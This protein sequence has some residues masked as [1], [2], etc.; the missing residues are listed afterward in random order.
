MNRIALSTGDIEY[1]DT[2]G[3]GPTVVFLHGWLMDSS[4]WDETIADLSA[5]HRCVAPTLPLGAHRLAMHA[6][7]DLSLPGIA[8]LVT[9]FL[10][11]LELRD[12]T[13]VGNDTGGAFV[14]ILMRD[15]SPRV[16]RVV[17]AS[18]DAFDN[19]PPGLTGKTLA[20]TGKLSPRLFGLF[21]QQM[22]LKFVRR[23]PIAFGWL[24]KRGD[25][26][27]ARWM[28]PVLTRPA[29]RR[30][31]VRMLRAASA[32]KGLLLDAA[33]D[34]PRF[35]RP[36]LVVWAGADRVMPPDHGRRLAE[37][38]PQAHLVEIDDSHTL[39]PLDQPT[40]LAQSIREFTTPTPPPPHHTP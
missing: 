21:M 13:L 22:R 25:A 2:G 27:T 39:L 18:C 24:T 16:T 6:D 40:K 23:L 7:A 9:E 36:A 12:V 15:G 5:D 38:L 1:E 3:N 35:D 29:I 14:Q 33:D 8:R 4:L 34:L 19:F 26:A 11:R 31:T 10:E 32:E 17:L 37:R 20:L 28:K 30:D